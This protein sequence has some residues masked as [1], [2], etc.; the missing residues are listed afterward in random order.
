MDL[1]KELDEKFSY[2]IRLSAAN[3][4]GYIVCYCGVSVRWQDSD[5]SHYISRSHLSLRYDTR[6][7]HPSCRECNRAMGGNL[8]PYARYLKRLYGADIIETLE[9][10]KWKVVKNFPYKEQIEHYKALIKAI[11]VV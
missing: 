4:Q 9:R 3:H 6:N 10:D 2:Y 5:A 1:I 11:V 8:Q 7:V